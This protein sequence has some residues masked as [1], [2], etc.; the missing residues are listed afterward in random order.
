MIIV[1]YLNM[2][3]CPCESHLIHFIGFA[4]VEANGG[5]IWCSFAHLLISEIEI[6]LSNLCKTPA[7]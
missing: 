1:A 2:T 4:R 6:R 5:V 3:C 7:N